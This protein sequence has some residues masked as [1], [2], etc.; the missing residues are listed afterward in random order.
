MFVGQDGDA[1]GETY[2][3]D[4]EVPNEPVKGRILLE[5]KGPRLTGFEVTADCLR[6][7]GAPP[8]IRRKVS[9][10]GRCLSFGQGGKPS[11]PGWHGLV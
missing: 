3:I 5:K 9:G 1:P 6:E 11:R 2:Q 8:R 7:R 10:R 4:V